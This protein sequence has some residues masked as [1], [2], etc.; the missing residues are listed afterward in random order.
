MSTLRRY[1][2]GIL[3]TAGI[4]AFFFGLEDLTNSRTVSLILLI[5]G[6]LSLVFGLTLR[7]WWHPVSGKHPGTG[8]VLERSGNQ[9]HHVVSR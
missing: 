1:V 5:V 2:G 9:G 4:F 3:A 8:H 7:L 6:L